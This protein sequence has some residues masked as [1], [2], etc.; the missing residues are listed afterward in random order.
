MNMF[1]VAQLSDVSMIPLAAPC[2]NRQQALQAKGTKG[3]GKA[4]NRSNRKRALR[5][6]EARVVG[7]V[8]SQNG[9]K[10][11]LGQNRGKEPRDTRLR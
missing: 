5:A 9:S 8:S 4:W 1:S 6:K 11:I 10:N 7:K 2:S 3:R